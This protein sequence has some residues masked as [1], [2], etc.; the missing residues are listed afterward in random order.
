MVK[1]KAG[2]R[3]LRCPG[4]FL[5]G[6][7]NGA[8]VRAGTALDAG[9]RVD[10][11]LAVSLAD[12]VHG[13]LGGTGAAADAFIGNLVSHCYTLQLCHVH[14]ERM[15]HF[16]LALKKDSCKWDLAPEPLFIRWRLIR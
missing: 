7:A 6:S 14:S 4:L 15:M 5:G 10:H 3:R 13:A 1:E 11:V 8:G 2:F 12:R 16:I 9:I